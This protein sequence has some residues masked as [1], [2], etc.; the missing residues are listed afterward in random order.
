MTKKLRVRVRVKR[1]TLQG[2]IQ[3][4]IPGFLLLLFLLF[5]M[6]LN[7]TDLFS[8]VWKSCHNGMVG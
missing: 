3:E 5:G 8:V 7:H 1:I 6:T 2:T 4:K